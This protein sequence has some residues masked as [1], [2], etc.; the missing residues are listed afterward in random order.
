[1]NTAL[2]ATFTKSKFDKNNHVEAIKEQMSK[3]E[4]NEVFVDEYTKSQN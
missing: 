1:M 4:W 3:I 2:N